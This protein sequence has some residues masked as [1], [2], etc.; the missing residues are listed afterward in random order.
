MII[1]N[2]LRLTLL[3]LTVGLV[4]CT[5]TIEPNQSRILVPPVL[6]R[7]TSAPAEASSEDV[8]ERVSLELPASPGQPLEFGLKYSIPPSKAPR[9]RS[10]PGPFLIP[11]SQNRVR[12]PSF[13]VNRPSYLSGLEQV[14]TLNPPSFTYRPEFP[15]QDW[16]FPQP[17]LKPF[18]S[19]SLSKEVLAFNP[20]GAKLRPRSPYCMPGHTSQNF[21]LYSVHDGLPLHP[22]VW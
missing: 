13:Q 16:S 15:E 8:T 9:I 10:L 11:R 18:Y 21:V 20:E 19:T 14:R 17:E 6:P 5:R 4:G 12:L 7:E 3:V 22:G 2:G 1:V